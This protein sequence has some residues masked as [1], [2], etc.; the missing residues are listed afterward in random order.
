MQTNEENSMEYEIRFFY[1]TT[2]LKSLQQLLDGSKNLT[3]SERYY[4]KTT[5]YDHPNKNES[6][7]QKSVDGR[8][9]LRTTKTDSLLTHKL[10]W[11]RRLNNT[12]NSKVNQEEEIEV[13]FTPDEFP[14]FLYIIEKILKMPKVESYERYRTL[15]YNDEIEISLNE[16]PFGIALEIENKSTQKD[17]TKIVEKW[18]GILKLD[19]NNAYR[20]SWDDKYS[21]LCKEQ[22]IPR[23]NHVE[24]G[25]PMPE[26]K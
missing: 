14:N 2:K 4:E 18:A 15:Y 5:Q 8:F 26:I 23:Y 21:E 19:I 11:K 6:F 13:H 12:A 7:Y 1:P 22:N 16:F 3:K 10:S 25:L 24:F 17:P 9:R 20:L